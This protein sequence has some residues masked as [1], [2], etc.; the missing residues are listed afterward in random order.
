[1]NNS[2]TSV[3]IPDRVTSIGDSVFH[4]NSLTSVIIPNSVTSIGFLAFLDNNQLTSV[5]IPFAS[6]TAADAVWGE[7]PDNWRYGIPG[8]VTWIFAP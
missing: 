4:N 1:M 5:T 2:L 6:L 8:T 7:L 3:I